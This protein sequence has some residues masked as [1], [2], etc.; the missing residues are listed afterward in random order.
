MSAVVSEE[1]GGRGEGGNGIPQGSVLTIW[2]GRV[3]TSAE[4]RLKVQHKARVT[5]PDLTDK[6][7]CHSYPKQTPH[8]HGVQ[9]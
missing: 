3:A 1:G 9:G 2:Q 5:S 4:R 6:G 7:R 8:H